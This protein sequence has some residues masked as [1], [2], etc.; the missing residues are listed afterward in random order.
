[1]VNLDKWGITPNFKAKHV[2]VRLTKYNK[3]KVR[4]T[5]SPKNG[6]SIPLFKKKKVPFKFSG[7]KLTHILS[8]AYTLAQSGK[9]QI[10]LTSGLKV[11]IEKI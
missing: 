2:N 4:L 8:G 3:K 1:M 9:R 7:K 11:I 6:N 10:L 5:I